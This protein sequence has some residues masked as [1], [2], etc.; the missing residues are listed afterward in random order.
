D[1]ERLAKQAGLRPPFI[2]V[3]SSMG[4]PTSEMFARRYPE[5]VA[6]LVFLD[7]GN[8]L[9]L[10]RVAT[11][12]SRREI[13]SACLIKPLARIGVLRMFDPFALRKE[14]SEAAQRSISRLYRVEPIATLCSLSRGFPGTR[15]EFADAAPLPSNIPLV[16][17]VHERAY[18][19]IPPK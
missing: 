6:G 2:L 12:F 15:Q 16:A 3:P 11:E 5:Q 8:S 13:E 10:E 17:L 9:I 1:L 4:G 19:F 14:G 18:G 7:A